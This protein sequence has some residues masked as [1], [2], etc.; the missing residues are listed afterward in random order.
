MGESAS[1]H[2]SR[3]APLRVSRRA[4]C[5]VS[6]AGLAGALTAP[7]RAAG[8][9]TSQ[10]PNILLIVSD[11][12][13][14]HLGCYGDANAP[15]PHLDALAA[16]GCRFTQAYVTQASCS[17]SRSSMFTGL[18]PHQNGQIGLAH[19]GYSM[20]PGLPTLPA[21][22]KGAGYRTGVIGKVHV[23]PEDAFPFDLDRSKPA[24]G[25][26]NVQ[27]TADLASEFMQ[28][29][30]EAPFF[31]MVNYFDPHR[32]YDDTGQIRGIPESPLGPD[33]V[34]PFPFLGLD[35]SRVRQ[36]TAAYYNA[37][38]RVDAGV[39]LLLERL[40]QAGGVGNTLVLFLGDHGPPFTRAKTTCYEAGLRVPFLL[41]WPGHGEPG[42]TSDTLVSTVDILPTL[43]AAAGIEPPETAGQSLLPWLTA[44]PP[45]GREVLCAEHTAHGPANYFPRRSIR[46]QRYK[47]ILNLLAGRP[48]PV[49]GVDGCAAWQA[50]RNPALE[51]SE[52]RGVYDT[53]HAP[54]AV[55][56]YDLEED[57]NEFHNLA[58]RPEVAEVQARLLSQL[59]AWRRETNDPLLAPETL[60]ALTK[61]H[62]AM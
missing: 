36:E 20:C 5:G 19:R 60:D 32:P 44:G 39:G 56:L 40:E 38:R 15:T 6:A 41:R 17:P 21:L 27:K 61:K 49:K 33:D 47:L 10:R 14:P 3:T 30:D 7:S 24:W 28:A 34:R 48:N 16:G 50:S 59:E 13:G 29:E 54:P 57:P 2:L 62:D 51:G 25:T 31:L 42:T 11:D 45:A 37:V 18:Y 22:F 58:G 23:A 35:T 4:F 46:G 1:D 8:E 9:E 43:L 53:Y 55:E 12:L 26:Q 52:I